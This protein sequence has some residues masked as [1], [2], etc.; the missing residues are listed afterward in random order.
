MSSDQTLMTFGDAIDNAKNGEKIQR[1]GWNG[2][3]MYV[4]WMPGNIYA[5][6]NITDNT[7][8]H[9][10]RDQPLVV[11]PYFAMWTAQKTWQ[12]G[13]LASQPDM[14]AEDWVIYRPPPPPP[15]EV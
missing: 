5:P 1:I 7:A 8:F 3:G 13:W 9:V 12:P 4:V 11:M 2:K 14:L 15:D 10:G 6:E